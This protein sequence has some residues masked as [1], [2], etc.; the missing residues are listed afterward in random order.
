VTVATWIGVALLG[1]AGAVGRFLLDAAV[2]ARAGRD[3]PFG[4]LAVNVSGAFVLG[5]LTGASLR[6]DALILAGGA[7]L[8]SFTTFSTWMFETQRLTEEGE[9]HAG[10][11][12]AAASLAVGIGAV[13]LGRLIGNHL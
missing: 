9:A 13:A 12:N 10:A 6:G 7:T 1:G 8:G 11:A 5:L 4:T 2:S 3:L